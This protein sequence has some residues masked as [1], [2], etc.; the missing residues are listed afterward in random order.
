MSLKKTRHIKGIIIVPDIEA[1]EGIE[2]ELKVDSADSKL[3]TTLGTAAREIVTDSQ[4]QEL[5]NKTLTS[6]VID[7]SVSGT[8]VETDLAVSAASDKLATASSIK[9]YVDAQIGTK[10]QADEILTNPSISGTVGESVQDVLLDHEIK[11]DDLVT[12]SGVPKNSTELGTFT[13][14]TIPDSS[15]IKQALQSL[16]TAHEEVDQNV[17]DLISLSGVAENATNLGTFTGSTIPDDSTVKGALQSVET[18]LETK[19]AATGGIFTNGS[20]VTP[21][22]L[23]VKQAALPDLVTY[24]LT[25]TNGQIVFATDEKKMFQ[26]VDGELVP[27]GGAGI[28]KLVA[29]EDI[30]VNDLVYISTGTGND[31]GRTAGQI[32]KADASNDD[33]ADILGFA[34][35]AINSGNIG[36]VQVSGNLSG[37]TGLT[38]GKVYYASASVPGEISLT[39]PAANG[40][41]VVAVGLSASDTE[42]II[43][44]VASSGAIY[45]VDADTTF[46][47]VNNQAS[48]TNITDLIFD[49]TVNRTFTLQYSIYRQTDTASSAVAQVGQLRGVYNTQAGVWFMSDDYSGQNAGVTFSIQPSGQIQYTSIEI[50]GAN[51]IGTLKYTITKSFGV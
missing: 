7:A 44:P 15:F 31:S 23:D 38:A 5:T 40:Q 11:T 47:I 32:Y 12:L 51:Y 43:N 39:S 8:A 26:V 36:E 25:A 2:G 46:T 20:I 16:E 45:I 37:F 10:D 42:I 1:L 50:L 3:K 33:R 22:R 27:I 48:A 49:G 28:V 30:L 35:K 13:G 4:T 24:A 18:S 41:W 19:L 9:S 14:N 17:N 21:T 34:T 6:P 29:G